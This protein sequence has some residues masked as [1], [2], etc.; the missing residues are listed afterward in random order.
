MTIGRKIA[1]SRKKAGLRQEDVGGAVGLTKA[2]ISQI[3]GDKL[4]G[5]PS[6]E[7]VVRIAE[8]LSDDTILSHYLENNPVYQSIIPKI[9]PDLNNI[10]REPAVIFSRFAA[11]A[12]EAVEAARILAEMFSNVDPTRT[13]NYRQILKN[14]LEQILDVQRCAE[15]LFLQLIQ[16]DVI[17]EEGRREVHANQQRKCVEHGHHIPEIE[18]FKS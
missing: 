14:K 11:E 9:F 4:K 15:I 7:L 3:E 13:P 2:G 5:G 12:E 18:E 1:E 16:C 10:R 6:P 8:F 17:T